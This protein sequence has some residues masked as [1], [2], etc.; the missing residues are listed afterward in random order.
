MGLHELLLKCIII[1]K[2]E[3]MKKMSEDLLG[4]HKEP[5]VFEIMSVPVTFSH[6]VTINEDFESPS[7]F[8]D[9]VEILDAAGSGDGVFIRLS[10]NGG[11]IHAILPLLGAMA[12]TEAHVH[13][14]LESDVAS[15]GTF[16]A[17]KADSVSINKHVSVM[18]HQ[19]KFG[20][21]GQGNHVQDH[22]A[23]V[24]KASKK[25]CE[26]MYENF[27]TPS[28][29]SRMLSGTEFYMDED[30]FMNRIETRN[31]LRDEISEDIPEE[32]LEKLTKPLPELTFIGIDG[33]FDSFGEETGKIQENKIVPDRRKTRGKVVA[34]SRDSGMM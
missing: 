27:L 13:V 12:S 19:V 1:N 6:R 3:H 20:S 10:T 18:C 33:A 4:L 28:E 14:H 15:A 17:M 11:A 7:Q 34:P 22:V 25:L 24:M 31:K 26:D 29:M 32:L 16:L 8:E 5:K 9:I 21:V 23:H 30:E 2:G